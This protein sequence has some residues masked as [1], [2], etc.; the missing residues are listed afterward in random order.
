MGTR[1]QPH[2]N[3]EDELTITRMKDGIINVVKTYILVRLVRSSFV[4]LLK[5]HRKQALLFYFCGNDTKT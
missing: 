2:F 4:G 1:A 5:W 3:Y